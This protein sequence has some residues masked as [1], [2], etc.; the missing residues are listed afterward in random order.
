VLPIGICSRDIISGLVTNK[1]ENFSQVKRFYSLFL[2]ISLIGPGGGKA[3]KCVAL[4][5]NLGISCKKYM[6]KRK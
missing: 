6:D 5:H 1:S 2:A 3:E 4:R